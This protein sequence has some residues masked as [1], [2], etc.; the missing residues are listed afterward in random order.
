M[1]HSPHIIPYLF[2]DHLY[3]NFDRMLTRHAPIP[4][5]FHLPSYHFSLINKYPPPK[6]VTLSSQN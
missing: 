5:L 1:K 6:L 3:F 4:R 2:F